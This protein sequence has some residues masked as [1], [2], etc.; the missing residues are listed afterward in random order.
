MGLTSIKWSKHHVYGFL[1]NH[2]HHIEQVDF[3]VIYKCH[4]C[5][6]SR[7]KPPKQKNHDQIMTT[8]SNMPSLILCKGHKGISTKYMTMY[9]CIITKEPYLKDMST[10]KRAPPCTHHSTGF[11][12]NQPYTSSYHVQHG[13]M[14]NMPSCMWVPR[15]KVPCAK[16]DH[17]VFM[18]LKIHISMGFIQKSSLCHINVQEACQGY[19][20]TMSRSSIHIRATSY[21]ND[22]R[23]GH[24]Y[25]QVHIICR[26]ALMPNLPYAE[27]TFSTQT[28]PSSLST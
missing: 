24:L 19:Q 21:T 26:W 28:C 22:H 14:G 7:P 27:D 11:K 20:G 4:V 10:K 18:V 25:H 16:H 6:D 15:S 5:G 2:D 23:M 1:C 9:G 12:R 3:N 13:I 8:K 17:H